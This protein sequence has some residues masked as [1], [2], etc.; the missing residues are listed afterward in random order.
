M[1]P[2]VSELWDFYSSRLGR[3]TRARLMRQLR[4]QWP[5]LSA[6][7]LLGFGY[8]TP[9]L[10]GFLNETGRVVALMPAGQGV[11]HWPAGHSGG[12]IPAKGLVGLSP[13]DDL[14]LPDNSMDR[15]LL[16]HCLEHTAHSRHLLR[17][18]WRVL[19]SGGR[20]MVV[21]PHR[22]SLWALS[23]KTPFGQGQPYSQGQLY[24]LLRDNMFQ[25]L[26]RRGALYLPPWRSR[27]LLR[28]AMPLEQMGQRFGVGLAGVLMV[29]ADK[30]IYAGTT[31]PVGR[32]VRAK[33]APA[34][35]G[36]RRSGTA[37]SGSFTG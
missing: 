34:V 3:V 22:R 7:A 19:A 4:A 37:D 32:P 33:V 25:P 20:L 6:Q 2:D 15:I 28:L 36:S 11:M 23:E 30:Q 26:S 16:V 1:R 24:R 8:A 10:A 18:V 9:Y 35:S 13:D 12:P 27:L 31:V 17:E 29:E 14:P 21:V 5:D